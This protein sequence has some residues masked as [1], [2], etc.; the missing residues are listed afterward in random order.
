MINIQ[1]TLRTATVLCNNVYSHYYLVGTV[2]H[3]Q[4]TSSQIRVCMCG[5]DHPPPSTA[6]AKERVELYFY[7]PS[8]PS[9]RLL[10]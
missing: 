2:I 4:S 3:T 7:P 1:L 6:E 5:V 9:C 8:G 10:G